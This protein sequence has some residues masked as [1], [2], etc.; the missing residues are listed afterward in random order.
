MNEFLYFCSLAFVSFGDLAIMLLASP[1]FSVNGSITKYR[2]KDKEKESLART[3]RKK[4]D[5]KLK[6]FFSLLGNN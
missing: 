2:V 1:S 4:T 5:R 3:T 6:R